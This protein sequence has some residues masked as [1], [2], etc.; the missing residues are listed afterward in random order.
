MGRSGF[1]N[2]T[3]SLQIRLRCHLVFACLFHM[4]NCILVFIKR[5]LLANVRVPW[6]RYFTRACNFLWLWLLV[7]SVL[8]I[9]DVFCPEG[10][11]MNKEAYTLVNYSLCVCELL[12]LLKTI[13]VKKKKK[14]YICK[15]CKYS[16]VSNGNRQ[17]AFPSAND[18]FRTFFHS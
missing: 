18:C 4:G 3:S 1:R 12:T 7:F 13:F 15:M 11:Q 14:R 5:L 16:V 2:L 17:E 6:N 10:L 8:V 9:L